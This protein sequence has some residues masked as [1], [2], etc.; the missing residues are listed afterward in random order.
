MIKDYCVF[1][2]EEI[3]NP[4]KDIF[5]IQYGAYHYGEIPCHLKKAADAFWHGACLKQFDHRFY[6]IIHAA[7]MKRVTKGD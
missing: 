5:C 3:H 6:E 2:G 4:G 1:C 7:Q